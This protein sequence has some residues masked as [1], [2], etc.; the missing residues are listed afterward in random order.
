MK[1]L[2]YNVLI[3]TQGLEKN[4]FLGYL[5]YFVRKFYSL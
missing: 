3:T 2:I 1:L 5:I 4:T